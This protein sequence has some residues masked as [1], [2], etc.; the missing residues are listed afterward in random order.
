VFR[1]LIII[2]FL[3]SSFA[4]FGQIEDVSIIKSSKNS[5]NVKFGYGYYGP[6]LSYGLGFTYERQIYQ[7]DNSFLLARAG[8]TYWALWGG[9]ANTYK[10]DLAY[11]LGKKNSHLEFDLGMI[12]AT[13]CNDSD[14]IICSSYEKF[15]LS[16]NIAYRYQKPGGRS[17][18]RVGIGR[19]A[20][21][22]VS[23]GFAF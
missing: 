9:S 7:F 23:Y 15:R 5:I 4:S 20:L 8:W 13:E 3:F 11:I 14:E 1:N 6:D 17:I 21:A 10:L 18:F 22:F 2:A 19:E 12:I 16:A